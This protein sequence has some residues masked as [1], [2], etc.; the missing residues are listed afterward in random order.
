M[1]ELLSPKEQRQLKILEYLFENPDWIY[2]D[3]LSKTIGYNARIIK[4]DIKELREIFPDFDIRHS[5]AGIMMVNTQNNGIER[6][7][8]YFLQTS[9]YFQILKAFFFLDS[10]F[11]YEHLFE[12]LDISLPSLRKKVADINKTLDGTYRF[13]LKVTPIS[14]IGD[15]KDIRFFFSQYF[16]EAYNFL[17]WPFTGVKEEDIDRFVSLFLGLAKF[18]AKYQNLYQIKTQAT[19]DLHRMKR[20]CLVQLPEQNAAW[21]NPIFDQLPDFQNLLQDLAQQLD[22]EITPDNLCQIFSPF[23][24]STLFFTVEDF[25]DARQSNEQVNRS[26]HAARDILDNLTREFGVQ[27]SNTDTLIWNLHNTALL[28]RREINSE[29]I[30][31]QNKDYTLRKIKKF[32]PRFYDA[33]VLEMV[34]YKNIMGQKEKTSAL[35]HL[36]YTLFTHAEGLTDQLFEYKKKVRVLVLSEYDFAHPQ[37]L[38][39][40]YEFHTSNNIQYETWDKETLNIDEIRQSDYDAIITNFDIKGINNKRIMNISRLSILQV[41]NELNKISMQDL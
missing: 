16:H 4:S 23:T 27:F 8:Q 6:I 37:C 21:L 39:S 19:V 7:Y 2:L 29:S 13:K 10:P 18:P 31:S 3:V 36:I 20:G 5:T 40:L 38:I 1:R 25:L 26:Y 14:I 15:E 24:E 34:R 41:V 32:F 28:E 33:T 11:T 35:S 12:T 17:E 30:I 9:D 22:I